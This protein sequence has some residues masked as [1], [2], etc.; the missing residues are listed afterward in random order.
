MPI[1]TP[2]FDAEKSLSTLRLY[3]SRQHYK[4]KTKQFFQNV[5][6]NYIDLWHDTPFYGKVNKENELIIPKKELLTFSA[7][8]KLV[9]FGFIRQA[10][11]E[12]RFFLQRGAYQGK[13]DLQN[14]FNN[15]QVKKS[16]EDILSV[17]L[18]YS[19]FVLEEYNQ[20]LIKTDKFI[21]TPKDYIVDFLKY[22][23]SNNILFSFYSFF[24]SPIASVRTSALAIEI[25]QQDHDNDKEKNKYFKNS[26]FEKYIK[27][28][29]NFG[30]RINKNAPWQLIADLNSKPMQDGHTIQK[31]NKTITT[32][33]YLVQHLIPN[34][35]LLFE[36]YY[37]KVIDIAFFAFKA[38]LFHGYQHYQERIKFITI[39]GKAK[40]HASMQFKAITGSDIERTSPT[41]IDIEENSFLEFSEKIS[42]C[43]FLRAFEKQLKSEFKVKNTIKYRN[44]RTR[45]YK[46]TKTDEK[47]FGTLKML[48]SFYKT[49]RIFNLNK[50]PYWNLSKN[51]NNFLTFSKSGVMI[52]AEKEAPTISK[53]VTEYYTGF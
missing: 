11:E 39:H 26:E 4:E 30:F 20:K 16:Y 6:N 52:P 21:T 13:T 51:K 3:R 18:D 8:D 53:I 7:D 22:L 46:S 32:P 49:T 38:V 19:F 44:F 31:N 17:Y 5:N 14:L 48:E 9:T 28:A 34:L 25:S 24:A 27:T 45:Y 50:K 43:F 47:T 41:I 12:M 10:F 42:N 33:G 29:A 15:F 23:K 2:D 40:I 36:G 37:D 35:N 1:Y